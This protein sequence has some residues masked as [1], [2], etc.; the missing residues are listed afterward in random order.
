MA[1]SEAISVFT[2]TIQSAATLSSALDLGRSW[3]K[4]ILEVPTM[5]VH[6]VT[7]TCTI[8]VQ[9]A[10][11]AAGSYR[12]LA[13]EILGDNSVSSGVLDFRY[14]SDTSNKMVFMPAGYQHVK[15]ETQATITATATFRV[16]ASDANK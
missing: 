3:G 16:I 5:S 12:R 6:A 9:V 2:T 4:L 8:F 7:G 15:I 1:G 14:P 13:M 10:H 11:S